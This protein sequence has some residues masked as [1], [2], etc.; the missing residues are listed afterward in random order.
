MDNGLKTLFALYKSNNW[1]EVNISDAEMAFAKESGY[2]FDYPEYE[3]H[4]DTLKRI[5]SVL[6]QIDP[7]D[8]A[9]AFLFSLSTRK[10]E[11]RSALGSYYYA[12]A[13]P[14]HEFMKSHN[15]ILA[16]AINQCYFCGWSAWEKEPSKSDI[17]FGYNYYNFD[18]YKYGG[19]PISPNVNYA[20]F[21]L[22]QFIKL[23]KVNPTDED[24]RIFANILSC[25]DSLKSS[26]KAG[27]LRDAIAKAKIFKSNRDEISVLLGQLGICGIL[28]SDEFPGYDV[29]FANEYERDPVEYKNDFAYPV[30][31]WHARDGINTERLIKVFG[32]DL[33]S[34]R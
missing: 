16:D 20:L 28:A 17:R 3:T 19:C 6:A 32:E 33:L 22:E 9:N 31:R 12:A 29:Y 7:K 14:E 13:I 26:D 11:Y 1:D 34:R 30:N 24:K 21:D 8:I 5:R 15:E 23:P 4:S 10:L 25:V 18:R 2:L 27:K